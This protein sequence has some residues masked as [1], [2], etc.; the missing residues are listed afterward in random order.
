MI[1]YSQ[2]IE[3]EEE[4]HKFEIAYRIYKDELFALAN[5]I[6]N[7]EH[8]AEDAV[9]YG[10]VKLAEN[11]LKI[12]DP[13]STKTKSYIVTIVENKAIDI[14][15]W[16]QRHPVAPLGNAAGGIRV[17]YDG[18]SDLAGC[19]LKLPPRQRSIII[20]KYHHGYTLKE[21]AKMLGISYSNA[22][23]IEFRAKEKLKSLCKEA[24]IEW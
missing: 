20:F 18:L 4:I 19:I 2:M 16:K 5:N 6:L 17:A 14:Y 1:V 8:D 3:T 11:I 7:N 9:H 15:R 23:K 13:R 24:E 22:L 21:I 12:G 10:F